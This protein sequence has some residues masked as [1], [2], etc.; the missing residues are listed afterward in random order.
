MDAGEHAGTPSTVGGTV[1]MG[2][3]GSPGSRDALRYALMAASRR[4]AELELVASYT[5]DLY[6]MTG[7]PVAFRE[8]AGTREDTEERAVDLLPEVAGQPGTAASCGRR[9]DRPGR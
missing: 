7:A 9:R 1:V 3:D 2:A 4:G 5:A 6:G 8:L